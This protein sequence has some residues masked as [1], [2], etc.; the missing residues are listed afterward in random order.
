MNERL[1]RGRSHV[2][3][4]KKRHDNDSMHLET[5]I[6]HGRHNLQA[7]YRALREKYVSIV[8]ETH[9]ALAASL[10]RAFNIITAVRTVHRLRPSF[11]A[12]CLPLQEANEGLA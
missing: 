4:Q 5:E 6:L 10:A 9:N 2:K 7:N 11:L 3:D 8:L 1:N 12:R